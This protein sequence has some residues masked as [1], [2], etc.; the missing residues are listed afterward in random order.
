MQ[1]IVFDFDGIIVDTELPI[2]KI[3][4][5]LYDSYGFILTKEKW[6]QAIGT[7]NNFDPIE[8][9]NLLLGQRGSKA[10]LGES[11][12]L[13]VQDQIKECM[14]ESI[15]P[16]FGVV[17]WLDEARDLGLKIGIASSSPNNWLLRFLGRLGLDSRFEAIVGVD[18]HLRP[19]PFS[20]VYEAACELLD[21]DPKLSLAVEDSRFGLIAAK[22]IQMKAIVLP[23]VLTA[24]DD[25]SLADLVLS[26]F[27]QTTLT[28]AIDS[29]NSKEGN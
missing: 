28:E 24:G 11:D 19:K 17:D 3:W 9:L 26:D 1:G 18:G 14:S 27:T 25:F 7:R 8:D 10:V 22:S 29:I 21:V 2:Y 4:A 15:E 6:R 23:S 5:G 13:N 12:Y 16:V 20:D